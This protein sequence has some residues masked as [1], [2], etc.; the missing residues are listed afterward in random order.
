MTVFT[1]YVRTAGQTGEKKSHLKFQTNTGLCGR[2][3]KNGCFQISPF[4]FGYHG[5]FPFNISEISQWNDTFRLHRP[6]PSHRTFGYC[7]CKQDTKERDW[8]QQ[9]LS[10]GKGH[11]GPTDRN[12]QTSQS[13]PPSKLIPKISVGPNRNGPFHLMYQ[14]KFPEFWVEFRTRFKLKLKTSRPQ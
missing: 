13:V 9:F 6:D 8:G 11:F 3:I 12:D 14:P 1:R 10:N 2:G 7:S 5:R 4:V